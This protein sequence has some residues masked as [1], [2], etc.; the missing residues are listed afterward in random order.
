MSILNSN[1]CKTNL[2][3]QKIVIT[4]YKKLTNAHFGSERVDRPGNRFKEM[5]VT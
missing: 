3:T 1:I 4:S 5:S 2:E